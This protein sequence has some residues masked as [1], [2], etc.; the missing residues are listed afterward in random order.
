MSIASYG[1]EQALA[2]ITRS[3][4]KQLVTRSDVVNNTLSG[5]PCIA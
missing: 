3:M 5:K 4:M 1:V 2:R